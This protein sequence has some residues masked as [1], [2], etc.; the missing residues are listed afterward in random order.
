MMILSAA[1]FALVGLLLVALSVALSLPNVRRR[2]VERGMDGSLRFP[3]YLA[4]LG[5]LCLVIALRRM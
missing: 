5:A 3:L 1:S 4:A 2:A